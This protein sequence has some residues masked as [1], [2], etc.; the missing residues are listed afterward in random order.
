MKAITGGLFYFL[1]HRHRMLVPV[2]GERS[3]IM[4]Q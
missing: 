3:Q 4:L 2:Y 1:K